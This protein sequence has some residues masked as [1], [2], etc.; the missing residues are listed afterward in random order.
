MRRTLRHARLIYRLYRTC[1]YSRAYALARVCNIPIA[2]CRRYF[3]RQ[4]PAC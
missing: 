3:D 2:T 4:E 1:G